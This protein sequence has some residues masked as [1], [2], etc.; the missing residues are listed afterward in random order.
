ML[1]SKLLQTVAMGTLFQIKADF[2]NGRIVFIRAFAWIS[3]T[4]MISCF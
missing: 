2:W 3:Y 1:V 4:K